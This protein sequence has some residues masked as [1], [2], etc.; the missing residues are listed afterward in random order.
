MGRRRKWLGS[1]NVEVDLSDVFSEI[2]D[3][4]MKEECAERGIYLGNYDRDYAERA[5]EA[6]LAGR[7][8]DGIALLD[9]ALYPRVLTKA[10]FTAAL[11]FTKAS[12]TAPT[13]A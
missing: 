4:D 9:Q 2:T 13:P 11:D 1:I 8:S 10:D 3:E 7:V 12:L 5:L 6:L